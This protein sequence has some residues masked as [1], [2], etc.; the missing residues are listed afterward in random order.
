MPK[1]SLSVYLTAVD[2]MSP[3]LASIT[4]K[5]KALDKESQQLEQ[6]YEALQKANRGLIA[7]KTELQ[8]QLQQVNEEVKDA[9]KQFKELGSEASS[10]A[11][12]KAQEKQQRLRDEIAATTKALQENQKTYKENIETIRKGGMEGQGTG[13]SDAATVLLTGQAGQML[14]SSLGGLAQSLLTSAIGTPDASL[15]S[16]ILSN[17]VSGGLAGVALGPVGILGGAVL[18]GVS[19]MISGNTK[20]YEEKDTAFKEYYNGLRDQFSGLAAERVS[21]GSSIAAGREDDL[22]ALSVLLDDDEQAARRFQQ[23][24]TELGRTPPFSYDTVSALSKDMLGLGLST[25]EALGR[26]NALAEAAAALDWSESSVSTVLSN[27]ESAQL[28]GKLD[29][30]VVKSLSKMGVNVYGALAEE[31]NISEDEVI[32]SLGDLDVNRAIDAIYEYLGAEFAGAAEGLTKTY[33]GASGILESYKADID[34]AAGE[35]YNTLRKDGI[36]TEIDSLGGALGDAMKEMNSIIGQNQ[37]YLENLSERYQRDALNA[38]FTGEISDL[39][40]YDQAET[41]SGIHADYEE[42]LAKYE[43]GDQEAGLRLQSLYELTQETAQLYYESSGIMQAKE[44]IE[45]EHLAAIRENTY[46]LASAQYEYNKQQEAS[47]GGM[48][49]KKGQEDFNHSFGSDVFRFML[50]PYTNTLSG[51]EF[52]LS[53]HA[54]GLDRVPYDDYPALLHEGE[55]VLTASEARAQDAEQGGGVTV[56]ITGNTFVGTSEEMADQLFEIIV[57]KLEQAYTAAAPK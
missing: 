47:K 23:S 48:S 14:S 30:R 41:L 25:D 33:S 9:R 26:I 1:E 57:R 12:E 42:A 39:F 45:L 54:F 38:L 7:R 17:A 43:A 34:S 37:A 29:T 50:S 27:L 16:D 6:T 55:R 22:R 4:D 2:G 3:V 56:P 19:G 35:G 15:A 21:G 53:S 31:F 11:Y 44:D 28:A 49:T 13:L 36:Q 18:G 8:K 46:G 40:D 24:L 32:G 10:D 5:T 20:I 51:Y 52:S